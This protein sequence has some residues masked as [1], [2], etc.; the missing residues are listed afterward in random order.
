[1]KW[2]RESGDEVEGFLVEI[3]WISSDF[4]EKL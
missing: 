1:M 4:Q 3:S 2:V